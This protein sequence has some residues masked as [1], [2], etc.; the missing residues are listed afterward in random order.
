MDNEEKLIN[1]NE[2]KLYKRTIYFYHFVNGQIFIDNNAKIIDNA[3]LLFENYFPIHNENCKLQPNKHLF[4]YLKT[5][6]INEK[7]IF[8]KY[9]SEKEYD[10]NKPLQDLMN[11]NNEK[12]DEDVVVKNTSYFLINL[13]NNI[14]AT[15]YNEGAGS[16]EKLLEMFIMNANIKKECFYLLPYVDENGINKRYSDYVKF[17]INNNSLFTTTLSSLYSMSSE[18]LDITKVEAE[19]KIKF[20][21]PTSN[22]FIKNLFSKI[23]PN[24]IIGEKKE[25]DEKFIY[26]MINNTFKIK[27][28]TSL[29]KVDDDNYDYYIN[30]LLH[31]ISKNITSKT[32]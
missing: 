30:L 19:I 24:K 4:Y 16:F 29:K 10:K 21:K 1:D 22:V 26:N 31:A 6:D 2:E 13:E 28:E 23:R 7:F 20:H 27:S 8:G 14:V 25:N 5:I 3:K 17:V 12:I 32:Y 18:N 11:K 9:I 15:V